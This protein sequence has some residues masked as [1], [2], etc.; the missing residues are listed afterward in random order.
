MHFKI[1]GGDELTSAAPIPSV[2][3]PMF[4]WSLAQKNAIFTFALSF[5]YYVT[6]IT[7]S[8]SSD[9]YHFRVDRSTSL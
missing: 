5:V 7:E 3:T 8:T 4:Y 9:H 1:M 2:P 6:S